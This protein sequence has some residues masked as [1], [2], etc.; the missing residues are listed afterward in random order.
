M[1]GTP[2]SA[3]YG[4]SG[5]RPGAGGGEQYPPQPGQ[6][7]NPEHA[8][9]SGAPEPGPA[10]G[11]HQM[12]GMAGY[13]Q[14]EGPGAAQY[15]SEPVEPP[16][17]LTPQSGAPLPPPGYGGGMPPQQPG[18]GMPPGNPPPPGGFGPGAM[19]PPAGQP[20]TG[21][22]PQQPYSAPRERLDVG[23]A[24]TYGWD[25]FRLNPVPWVGMVLIGLIAWLVVTLLVNLVQ[26]QSLSAVILLFAVASLIVWL[27]QAAMIRGALYETDGTPPDFPAFFGFVN[28]GN[29]L[30]TALIVFALSFVAAILCVFPAVIVGVLCMFSLHFVID[31][32]MNPIAA[33]GSSVRLVI[34]NA[35]HV[36]LLA[37][38]VL[39]IT[40]IGV[41]L[42]GL[43]LL[44]AG[45]VT[46]IATTYAYRSLTGRLVVPV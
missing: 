26:V 20:P 19:P 46:A 17:P 9:V 16:P 14:F 12:P 25:R 42:C 2:P 44:V 5:D 37:L 33:I 13:P 1:T 41:L 35:L 32:D 31:Q 22:I 10:H 15:G 11:R 27:L 38:A 28:A 7:Q 29:V 24:L 34:A 30:I 40:A 36:T 3:P 45:P 43:G 21:P 4:P 6:H 39:I 23:A 8:P 18:G